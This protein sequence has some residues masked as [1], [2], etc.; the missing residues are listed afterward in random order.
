MAFQVQLPV[1]VVDTLHGMAGLIPAVEFTFQIQLVSRG[2]PFAVDPA[3][4]GTVETI[5]VVRIGKVVQCLSLRK[6]A[7][8]GG[9]VQEHTKINVTGE[10]LQL[11]VQF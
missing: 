9:P 7:A 8:F 3:G 10:G 11:G 2:C 1:A 4:I 6:Q 5:I